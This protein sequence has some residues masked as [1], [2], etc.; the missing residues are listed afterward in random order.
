MV[1]D[2]LK[3]QHMLFAAI[4]LPLLGIFFRQ[5]YWVIAN[6]GN[7]KFSLSRIMEGGFSGLGVAFGMAIVFRCQIGTTKRAKLMPYV[8]GGVG[9]LFVKIYYWLFPATN[10]Y[11]HQNNAGK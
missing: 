9:V 8:C 3:G 7:I 6:P 10:S 1:D 2:K 11:R 4:C 5:L